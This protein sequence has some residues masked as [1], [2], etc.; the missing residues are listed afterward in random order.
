MPRSAHEVAD[1]VAQGGRRRADRPDGRHRALVHA[2]RGHRRRAAAPRRADRHQVGRRGGRPGHRR[3]RLPAARAQR[4][5]AG[6][7]A[8]AGQHGRHPGA[9]GGRRDPDRH[10]RHRP[11]HRRHGRPGRRPGAGPGRRTHRDLLGGLARRRPDRP[12]RPRARRPVRRCPGG[13]RRARGGHRR[14]V[15]GSA[16]VPARGARR[17]DALVRGDLPAGRADL[18]KRAL[19]VLLVPAHR[20]LP[21]QAEQPLAR[22]APAAAQVAVPARRRVPV[23]HGVRRHLQAGARGSRR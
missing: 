22:A 13:P 4:Q 16:R 8:V 18:G 3:G 17:A 19:R 15:P 1:E 6:P 10:A 21:D 23:Q 5:P 9:D 14:H 2:G 7:R 12:G 11:R 20:G